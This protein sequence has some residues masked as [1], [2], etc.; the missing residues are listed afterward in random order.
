MD[1]DHFKAVNDTY[2]NQAGD[3]VLRE[4]GALLG[5]QTRKSET[6]LKARKKDI[7]N[8]EILN[9]NIIQSISSGLVALDEHGRKIIDA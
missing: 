6:E 5:E 1:L 2:G 3:R 4:M 8:L 9:E 7:A